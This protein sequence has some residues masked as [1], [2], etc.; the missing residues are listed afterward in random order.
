M[1]KRA[2]LVSTSKSEKLLYPIVSVVEQHVERLLMQTHAGPGG[3]E[4]GYSGFIE[5]G[6]SGL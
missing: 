6:L 2:C 3:M 5:Q 4:V 1:N